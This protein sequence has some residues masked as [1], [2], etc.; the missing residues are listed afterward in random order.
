MAAGSARQAERRLV[1]AEI[2][3]AVVGA[4]ESSCGLLASCE[5]DEIHVIWD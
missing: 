4:R 1:V 2:V 3:K 5:V